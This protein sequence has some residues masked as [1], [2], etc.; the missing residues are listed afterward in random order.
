MAT[1]AVSV[2]N[3]KA[4]FEFEILQSYT[5]GIKL[6]GSEIKS[7]RDGK[8]N[9]ADAYCYFEKGELY[10]KN[11]HIAEYVFASHYNHEPKRA[12]KLLLKKSELAKLEAKLKEK[13]LAIIPVHL[14]IN[15]K[16]L[17]KLEIALGRGKKL[18]DKRESIKKRDTGR[19]LDRIK[20]TY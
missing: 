10:V 7:L 5:A 16:G 9:L 1:A 11:M 2:K 4:F 12:R 13:G 20:K 6:M 18:Y 14:F 19:E 17:A 3:K 8:A 15:D